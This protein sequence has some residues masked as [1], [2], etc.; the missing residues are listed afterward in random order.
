MKSPK[1]MVRSNSTN[2]IDKH[3]ATDTREN[4]ERRSELDAD[5]PG[6]HCE[7]FDM[8]EIGTY[9]ACATNGRLCL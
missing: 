4:S 3:S 9:T 6:Y 5:Y 2:A 1:A 7:H 8:Q